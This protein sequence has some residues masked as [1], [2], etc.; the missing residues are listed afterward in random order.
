L[1][2]DAAIADVVEE[3]RLPE[4]VSSF[5]RE[6][7]LRASPAQFVSAASAGAAAKNGTNESFGAQDSADSD[8]DD[9]HAPGEAADSSCDTDNNQK[10][11]SHSADVIPETEE[12]DHVVQPPKFSDSSPS[13]AKQH[14]NRELT[15]CQLPLMKID[16][17]PAS[18]FTGPSVTAIGEAMCLQRSTDDLVAQADSPN[19]SQA[20]EYSDEFEESAD[21]KTVVRRVSFAPGDV[22]AV[23]EIRELFTEA[24]AKELFFSGPL[25]L[26][27]DVSHADDPEESDDGGGDSEQG[28]SKDS[29]PDRTTPRM[30]NYDDF[31]ELDASIEA[32]V[33]E[34]NS[35]DSF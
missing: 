5:R 7:Q 16:T 27:E 9:V 25:D 19:Q 13:Q 21:K 4:T 20:L 28:Q 18:S 2:I 24:Q 6:L 3:L 11:S 34:H 33:V 17:S 14:P 31:V 22:T 15:E 26:F 12:V 32:E 8:V 23:H 10:L 30:A 29:N 35:D 1:S